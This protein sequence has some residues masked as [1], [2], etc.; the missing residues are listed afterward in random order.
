[1]KPIEQQNV[2]LKR[3]YDELLNGFQAVSAALHPGYTNFGTFFR[4][5]ALQSG[6]V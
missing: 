3:R 6:V 4:K 5:G 1:M 2:K